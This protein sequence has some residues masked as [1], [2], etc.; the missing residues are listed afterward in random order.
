MLQAPGLGVAANMNVSVS[1]GSRFF[2]G[3]PA[4]SRSAYL[5][6]SNGNPHLFQQY[7]VV[8]SVNPRVGSMAGKL[9]SNS[10]KRVSGYLV[11][12]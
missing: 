8:D 4:V 12:K 11:T 2:N 1:Y 6:D 10:D 9:K 7:A 3:A 5:P